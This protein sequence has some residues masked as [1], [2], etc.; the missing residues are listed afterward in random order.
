MI[1]RLSTQYDIVK[2]T[3]QVGEIEF[4][5][6]PFIRTLNYR[7]AIHGLTG[8]EDLNVAEHI[9]TVTIVAGNARQGYRSLLGLVM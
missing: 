1:T 5:S 9:H 4:T 6:P 7:R 2:L 3:V 8:V